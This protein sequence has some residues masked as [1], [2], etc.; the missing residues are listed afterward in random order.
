MRGRAELA[1]AAPG[2]EADAEREEALRAVV[3]D[4]ERLDAT[5]GTL[6]AIARQELDPSAGSVD[7]GELAREFEDVREVRRRGLPNAE[8]EPD[9]V[10]RALSP[11]VDNARRHARAAGVAAS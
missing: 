10:R 5:I 11:L 7:L 1:L 9:V 6:I 8:G 4:A 3:A 2:S